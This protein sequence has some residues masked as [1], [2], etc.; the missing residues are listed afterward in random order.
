MLIKEDKMRRVL[1]VSIALVILLSSFSAAFAAEPEQ[2]VPEAILG[3]VWWFW[4]GPWFPY[5]RVDMYLYRPPTC[6]WDVILEMC[7]SPPT[8]PATGLLGN[9]WG[10]PYYGTW[11]W[12]GPDSEQRRQSWP[13]YQYADDFGW[14]YAEFMLPR[15]EVW[16]PCS[17]PYKWKCNYLLYPGDPIFPPVVEWHSPANQNFFLMPWPWWASWMSPL[18]PNAWFVADPMD[19]VSPLEALMIGESGRAISFPFEVTGYYWIWTDL[20]NGWYDVPFP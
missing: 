4:A 8:W 18:D 2:V 7:V 13:T 15:D 9:P 16:F 12:A 20:E 3:E 1:F 17:Y 19:T 6:V 14:Y 10:G 11:W 5:E